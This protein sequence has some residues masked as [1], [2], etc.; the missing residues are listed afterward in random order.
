MIGKKVQLYTDRMCV[1]CCTHH[2][3]IPAFCPRPACPAFPP[4]A[5]AGSEMISLMRM[6]EPDAA[7]L[8]DRVRLLAGLKAALPD[9]VIENPA[10]L[11]AYASDGLTAYEQIPL[12][13]ALPR[14]TGEVSRLLAFCHSTGLKVVPRGA[15]TSLSGG[16]LPLADS[17]VI[18]M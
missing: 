10:E 9:G 16:A 2:S 7:L 15:G 14:N 1:E 6:P 3:L 5:L 13:V 18:G 8:A 11:T 4:R 12:A 17:V